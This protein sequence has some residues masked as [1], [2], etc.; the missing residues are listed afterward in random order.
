MI[1]NSSIFSFFFS[2][3]GHS[4]GSIPQIAT[5]SDSNRPKTKGGETIKAIDKDI[6]TFEEIIDALHKKQFIGAL[7]LCKLNAD[8][9][10]KPKGVI[11]NQLKHNIRLDMCDGTQY[12]LMYAQHM[13]SDCK[14]I[15]KLQKKGD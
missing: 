8:I 7:N 12:G 14:F 10:Y 15:K 5:G 9:Y 13:L 3:T 2:L 4:W 1:I 6:R 11:A